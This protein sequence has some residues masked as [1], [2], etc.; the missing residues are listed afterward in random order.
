MRLA[1]SPTLLLAVASVGLLSAVARA[2]DRDEGTFGDLDNTSPGTG[3]SYLTFQSVSGTV[4][5]S[6]LADYFELTNLPAGGTVSFAL[7]YANS[8]NAP[9][10]ELVVTDS[11]DTPLISV[12]GLTGAS[13]FNQPDFTIP[14]DGILRF[15][16]TTSFEGEGA[17]TYS[18]AFN[19]TAL[20]PV[21]E[22]STSAAVAVAGLAALMARRRKK[23]VS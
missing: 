19:T 3:V 5:Q 7:D 14:D 8:G 2:A 1:S 11:L 13:T 17:F 15:G 23:I 10:G 16:I 4:T 21:P 6:D 12:S 20:E 22:G 18:L 9:G